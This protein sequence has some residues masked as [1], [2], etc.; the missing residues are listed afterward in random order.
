MVITQG[1]PKH[2]PA[3]LFTLSLGD[4]LA[5]LCSFHDPVTPAWIWAFHP[6]THSE[7]R[8]GDR[9]HTP[10]RAHTRLVHR[11]GHRRPWIEGLP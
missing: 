3:D 2:S 10:Q 6:Q 5:C 1:A 11:D 8:C 4:D 9:L 7:F